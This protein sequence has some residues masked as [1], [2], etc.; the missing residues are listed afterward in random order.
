M[1]NTPAD[2]LDLRHQLSAVTGL[3][4]PA[5]LGIVGD[6]AHART[7]GY[8]EGR[9]VLVAL[10]RYHAPPASHVG[11]LDEDYSV[12]LLRDRLG[13]TD[14]A[15]AMD[16]GDDWPHGGRDAWLRFNNALVGALAAGDPALSAVRAVNY[17]PDGVNRYRV[18]RQN[19][20]RHQ[21]TTDSVTMH[22][23][24]EFFRDTAGR[25]S[26][27][28]ARL[29]QL[30]Q[31]A[32]TPSSAPAVT[33]AVQGDT[34]ITLA[35][36]PSG[37]IYRCEAGKSLPVPSEQ[38]LQAILWA[39]QRGAV[40]VAKSPTGGPTPEWETYGSYGPVIYKGGWDEVI[41]GPRPETELE[42]VV[43]V[44]AIAAKAAALVL[45]GLQGQ[46]GLTADE[47]TAAVVAGLGH[48]R[49]T[50]QAA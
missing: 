4:N 39:A 48:L 25:R 45:A 32:I 37:A 7:G 50:V 47:L 2:L 49:L 36:L 9:D 43:D 24:V 11:S 19:G 15:S 40:Q 31:L 23:H 16:I 27:T 13:L 38:K 26:A 5:D 41:F 35:K 17:S 12:R 22:T 34:M 44:D 14:D 1:T 18:D 42:P 10:G 29:V 33:P 46:T 20:W 8:H 21:S 3:T 28:I 6:G 30:A